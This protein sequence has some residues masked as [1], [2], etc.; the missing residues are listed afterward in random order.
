MTFFVGA[1]ATIAK[2]LKAPDQEL[3]YD[4]LR[5]HP[6][7]RGF[8]IP[9]A[10]VWAGEDLAHVRARLGDEAE[11]V[12]TTIPGLF[13]RGGQN[14][15][16]GPASADESGR[17]E[18]LTFL[19]N[20][21][22]ATR[23][24]AEIIGPER[25]AAV[26]IAS[27]P[28]RT[29]MIGHEGRSRFADSMTEVLSWDW[30]STR[31]VVEHCDAFTDSGQSAKG[32]LALDDEIFAVLQANAVSERNAVVGVNWGRSAIEGRSATTP[33]E[34]LQIAIDA[35]VLGEMIFSGCSSQPSEYGRAW[36]DAHVPSVA[37][38][39]TSLLTAM[40]IAECLELLTDL[41]DPVLTGL[42]I[43]APASFTAQ[44]RLGM[45]D[46]EL[47]LLATARRVWAR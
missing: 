21:W 11:V 41:S 45:L 44:E 9:F 14:P 26:S 23:R 16:F 19:H 12:L 28:T 46:R 35:G 10:D 20:A 17:R 29:S 37:E 33:L 15:L 22:D 3:V 32:Y 40:S 30:G 36:A 8:E 42:K 6:L 4:V 13:G 39:P 25:I 1:Y 43:S 31:V 27:A 2:G 7:V 24:L 47:Q 18:S 5:R 34:H 38:E